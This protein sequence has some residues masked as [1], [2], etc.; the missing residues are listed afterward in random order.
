MSVKIQASILVIRLSSIQ[1]PIH[2]IRC[3]TRVTALY[4]QVALSHGPVGL[5]S[6]TARAY[7]AALYRIQPIHYTALYADPLWGRGYG[8][9]SMSDFLTESSQPVSDGRKRKGKPSK[10]HINSH[11]EHYVR[12]QL[13]TLRFS[14]SAT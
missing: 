12:P 14:L 2:E 7:T 10:E 11:T 13:A 3:I 8:V 1:H 9:P 6:Y 4:S 5:Y